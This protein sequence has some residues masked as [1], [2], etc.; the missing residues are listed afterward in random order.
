[1]KFVQIV[2]SGNVLYALTQ[3]GRIFQR[4]DRVWKEIPLPQSTVK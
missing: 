1:M 2:Y 3:D 4:Y